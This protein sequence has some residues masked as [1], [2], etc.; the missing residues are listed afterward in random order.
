MRRQLIG[1][2]EALSH[3]LPRQ[4]FFERDFPNFYMPEEFKEMFQVHIDGTSDQE[5]L[6]A[7][8]I[9]LNLESSMLILS[10]YV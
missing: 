10:L 8:V 4:Q 6:D 5:P 3:E 1:F 7:T 9:H 2:T